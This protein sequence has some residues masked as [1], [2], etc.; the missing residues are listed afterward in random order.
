MEILDKLK[1]ALRALQRLDGV[2]GCWVEGEE[3]EIFHVYAVTP[4]AD[5]DLDQRIFQ[6]Y[7]EVMQQ[8]PEASF[9]F[10]TTSHPPAPRS[11]IVF[12]SPYSSSPPIAKAIAS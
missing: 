5:Y 8:F 4:T 11:E 12:Y 3:G 1:D 7:T 9:E 2:E 6:V 10:L